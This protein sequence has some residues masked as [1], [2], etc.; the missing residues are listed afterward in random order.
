MYVLQAKYTYS[1][2]NSCER[3]FW[4]LVLDFI[5]IIRNAPETLS[6][7]TPSEVSRFFHL[8]TDLVPFL[9]N[10]PTHLPT[11][12]S[13]ESKIRLGVEKIQ[14]RIHDS[15]FEIRHVNGINHLVLHGTNIAITMLPPVQVPVTT[16]DEIVD[17]FIVV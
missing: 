1:M 14:L 8:V 3:V 5:D 12:A 7:Y 4:E 6:D 11:T 17:D 13:V 2:P 10:L 15:L 16:V 9:T